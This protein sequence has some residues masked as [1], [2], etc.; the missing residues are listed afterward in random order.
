MR[1]EPGKTYRVTHIRKGKFTLL[2]TAVTPAF[3][4]GKIL[5]GRVGML[6]AANPDKVAGDFISVRTSLAA[7]EEVS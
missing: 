4:D 5:E 3:V 7:F 1:I 6:S 2:V